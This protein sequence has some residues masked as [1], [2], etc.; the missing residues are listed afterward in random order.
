MAKRKGACKNHPDIESSRRCFYCK[1][2][3][4]TS[5]QEK[6]EHH[7]F[8]GLTCYT[9]WKLQHV[10]NWIKS[11]R[12]FSFLL[13]FL[14]VSDILLYTLLKTEPVHL[15][16]DATI[17]DTTTMVDSSW[18]RL[19]TTRVA[20]DY[21]LS[22][23]LETSGIKNPV[24]LWKN[25]KYISSLKA[26]EGRLDFGT[27][28]LDNGENCFSIWT[29]DEQGR[30]N[31]VDSFRI[32]YSSARIDYLKKQVSRI[33]TSEKRLALTFDGGSSNK[34]TLN[35][36][37]TLKSRNIK[38]TMFLTGRFIKLFP[39]Y[40]LRMVRDGHEIGNHSYRHPHLTNLEVDGSSISREYV[41]RNY[42][43]KELEGAD[44]LFDTIT[45]HHM[46]SLWRAPYGEVNEDI[47]HWA[48]EAGY[49]HIN[50]SLK[51]D[52]W[53]WVADTTSNLYR[54]AAEI[55]DHY[56]ELDSKSRLNG[57]ILLMHLGSERKDDFPYH[58]LGK[59]ID[60]LQKRGYRLVTISELLSPVQT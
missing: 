42:I 55:Y 41:N 33:Y 40:V 37:D 51:G 19:D 13:L 56:I 11:H 3:I 24:F 32:I 4:C 26:K 27:Q 49:K 31:V 34:T 29:M 39:D 44:S 20:L 14:I 52:S 60:T 36:L 21:G 47:I 25:G 46:S 5:C 22:I 7:L 28:Y 58:F 8:C 30:T 43:Q 9:R 59:L 2:Y 18:I 16:I 45:G 35:I 10:G 38:C 23:F 15:P 17:Q 54:S 1:E 57:R 53:D 50:W 12:D 6:H 48:A